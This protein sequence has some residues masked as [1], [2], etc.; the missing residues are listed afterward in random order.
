MDDLYGFGLKS[1]K[2]WETALGAKRLIKIEIFDF[3]H[4]VPFIVFKLKQ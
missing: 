4:I 1:V 2:M 3:V